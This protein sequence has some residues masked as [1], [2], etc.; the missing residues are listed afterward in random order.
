MDVRTMVGFKDLVDGDLVELTI[1]DKKMTLPVI[2][3][4]GQMPGTVSLALGYGSTKL[5]YRNNVGVNV[6]D[7]LTMGADGPGIIIHQ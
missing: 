4:F 6:N 2:Q 1:G 5:E 3:Q 7:C